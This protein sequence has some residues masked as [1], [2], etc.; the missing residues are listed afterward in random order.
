MN[1]Y[2]PRTRT[3]KIAVG[4]FLL[5]FLFCQPPLVFWLANRIE[6]VLLGMPFLFVYLLAAYFALIGVLIWARWKGL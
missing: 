2:L 6:P 1:H 4:L 3:G 5:L